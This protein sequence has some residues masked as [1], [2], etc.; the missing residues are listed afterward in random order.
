MSRL[1]VDHKA[2]QVHFLDE[3]FYNV[4]DEQYYPSVT[5]ILD[6]YPKGPAFSQWLK[7]VG[8]NAKIIAERAAESG[9]KVHEACERLV[10]GEEL[11]WDD[12]KYDLNEW[13]GVLR[14]YD[15]VSRFEPEWEAVEV[16]TISHKYRYAGTID[17]VCKFGDKTWLLDI[18]FGNAIYDTY[19]MQLAA[20]RQSWNETNPDHQIDEMGILWLKANTRT[21]GRKGA[22]QGVGWQLVKPKDTYE[23]LFEIFKH[24][25]DI[26]YF[27]NPDPKPKNLVLLSKIKL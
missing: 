17:L 1:F 15:F 5:T 8:N 21:E 2:K 12:N 10:N 19:F 9:S 14:F 4:G 3:R 7:D 16:T 13:Q 18:K 6:L 25:L 24:V 27:E 22:V 11:E 26:Y 23:R 20:Y